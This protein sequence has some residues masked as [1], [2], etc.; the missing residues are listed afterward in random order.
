MAGGQKVTV[1]VLSDVACGAGSFSA[2]DVVEI[3][4]ALAAGLGDHVK[5]VK[6]G[7]KARKAPPEDK[8][9]GLNMKNAASLSRSARRGDVV[10]G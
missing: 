8:G 1:E 5:I 4:N 3:D 6:P 2:G 9:G 7:T 10:E